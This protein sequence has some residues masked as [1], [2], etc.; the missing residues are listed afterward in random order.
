MCSLEDAGKIANT[1]VIQARGQNVALDTNQLAHYTL[2]I[3]VVISE[4]KEELLATIARADAALYQAKNTG[5][6]R[7]CLA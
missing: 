2:S 3:G 6:D 4:D 5:R 7:V 1:I